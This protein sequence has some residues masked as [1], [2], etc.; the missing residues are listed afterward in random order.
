MELDPNI[1]RVR[2]GGLLRKHVRPGP[3]EELARPHTGDQVLGDH[4]SLRAVAVLLD[5]KNRSTSPGAVNPKCPDTT[6]DHMKF[7]PARTSGTESP[8]QELNLV[9]RLV[10][11][12]CASYTNRCLEP[13]PPPGGS[14]KF[15]STTSV[16]SG[17]I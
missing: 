7:K 6:V 8:A 5:G 9:L 4:L 16:N 11:G 13:Y 1:I 14:D 15:M 3:R 10:Q 2:V 17:S 12:R